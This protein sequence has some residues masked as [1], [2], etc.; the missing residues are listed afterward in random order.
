MLM[1][2]IS[3]QRFDFVEQHDARAGRRGLAYD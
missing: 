1:M 3:R 2:V